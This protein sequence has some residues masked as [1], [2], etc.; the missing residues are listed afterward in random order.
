MVRVFPATAGNNVLEWSVKVSDRSDNYLRFFVD[1]NSAESLL[2]VI[3]LRDAR[4]RKATFYRF[5]RCELKTENRMRSASRNFD[6]H[7]TGFFSEYI[8]Y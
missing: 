6:S 8:D 2:I 5:I 7:F 1:S 4:Q 3:T